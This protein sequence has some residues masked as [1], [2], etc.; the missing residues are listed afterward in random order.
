MTFEELLA[1][2][3]P[4]MTF[5]AGD[6]ISGHPGCCDTCQNAQL[7]LLA[8]IAWKLEEIERRLPGQP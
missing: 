4:G 5:T 2:I 6:W 1:E 3:F 7:V 8:Y